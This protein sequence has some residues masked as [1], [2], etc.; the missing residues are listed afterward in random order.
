VAIVETDFG[1]TLSVRRLLARPI[2]HMAA[3]F[4]SEK[5]KQG[6]DYDT[7]KKVEFS[8]TEPW[9]EQSVREPIGKH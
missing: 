8:P 1:L 6:R 5:D 3:L 9:G 2:T 7:A 4:Q